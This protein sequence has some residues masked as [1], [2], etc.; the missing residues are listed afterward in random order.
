MPKAA[1]ARPLPTRQ[2]RQKG[3][4]NFLYPRLKQAV[5]DGKQHSTP[6]ELIVRQADSFRTVR[7]DYREGLRYPHLR[8]IEGTADLLTR[9]L[10]ARR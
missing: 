1:L 4:L 9:I 5:K 3:R 2:T 7:I 10:A 6:I 8:R